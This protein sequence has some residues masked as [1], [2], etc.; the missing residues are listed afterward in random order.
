MDFTE[1][2]M[3]ARNLYQKVKGIRNWPQN[4]DQTT[5]SLD[6]GVNYC[7]SNHQIKVFL[8]WNSIAGGSSNLRKKKNIFL[9]F[10]GEK[11]SKKKKEELP[12]RMYILHRN[13]MSP[14]ILM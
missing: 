8:T 3:L 9:D 7:Y 13:Q 1:R 2:L 5:S 11:K 12:L 4:S 6:T 14:F 10:G